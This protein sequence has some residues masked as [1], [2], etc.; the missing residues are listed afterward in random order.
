[1]RQQ[2]EQT[3]HISKALHTGGLDLFRIVGVGRAY[4]QNCCG[5]ALSILEFCSDETN[6]SDNT[7]CSYNKTVSLE[8]KGAQRSVSGM[9]HLWRPQ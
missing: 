9:T 2:S 7:T 1:M 3:V 4:A 5:G 6:E 8:S